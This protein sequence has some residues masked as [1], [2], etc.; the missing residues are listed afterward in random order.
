MPTRHTATR[1]EGHR[2]TSASVIAWPS[3]T[4]GLQHWRRTAKCNHRC[5]AARRPM[6]PA[7]RLMRR[8]CSATKATSCS[9]SCG[10]RTTMGT[11]TC[12]HG[13]NHPGKMRRTWRHSGLDLD[14]VHEIEPKAAREIRPAV[15]ITDHGLERSGASFVSH[16]F[17]LPSR[18]ARKACDWLRKSPYWPDRRAPAL[19]DV[20]RDD[21]GVLRIKPVMRV[22][23]AMRVTI[24]GADGH[25]AHFQKWRW[26]K[27][28]ST[29]PGPPR[30]ISGPPAC[31]S[32]RS[33]HRS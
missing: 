3:P 28:A 17:S 1:N 20:R 26:H 12:T 25:A 15:V 18:R 22:A 16:S 4:A 19:Q 2:N 29:Y 30:L 21:F 27:E 8:F 10:S 33:N 23:V 6:P 24:A 13:R 32:S 14:E 9:G 7:R 5:A 11:L 31:A